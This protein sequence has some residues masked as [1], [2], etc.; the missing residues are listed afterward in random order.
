MCGFFHF[1][2]VYIIKTWLP[3]NELKTPSHLSICPFVR[4]AVPFELRIAATPTVDRSRSESL[5]PLGRAVRKKIRTFFVRPPKGPPK[6][7]VVCAC[8]KPRK[9]RTKPHLFKIVVLT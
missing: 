3:G 7:P 8:A 5:R 6:G 4:S 2:L 1:N 9:P